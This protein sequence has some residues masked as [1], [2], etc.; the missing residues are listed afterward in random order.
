MFRGTNWPKTTTLAH[1]GHRPEVFPFLL[2]K[3]TLFFC[4]KTKGLLDLQALS[5][6]AWKLLLI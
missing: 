5:I 3:Q 1:V 6:L 4:L 2:L